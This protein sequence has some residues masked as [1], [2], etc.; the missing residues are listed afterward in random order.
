MMIFFGKQSKHQRNQLMKGRMWRWILKKKEPA[1][2][3]LS[4]GDPR[5]QE[6][7]DL[8]EH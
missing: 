5:D 1:G 6:L 7:P 3:R 2:S 4:A 8:S